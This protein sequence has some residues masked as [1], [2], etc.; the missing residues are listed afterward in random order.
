MRFLFILFTSLCLLS[1]N[2]IAQTRYSISGDVKDKTNNSISHAIIS[3]ENTT[4]GTATNNDGHYSLSLHPGKY[5]IQAAALGYKTQKK[6]IDLRKNETLIFV[7]EDVDVDLS[8][9]EILG[10]SKSQQINEGSFTAKSLDVS[11]T[12]SSLNN[13]NALVGKS[14]GIKIREDGGVGS[15]FDLS[16]NGLSGNSV[17]YFIDG[18]PLTSMG[19]GV[20]LANYPIN[21]VERVEIYKGVVPTELGADALGGAVNIVTKKAIKNYLDASVGAGSFNTYKADFN[22]QFT[23]SKSGIFIRPSIATNYSKNN[24]TMKGVEVWNASNQQFEKVNVKRFHDDYFSFLG[25]VTTGVR[26][27]SWADLLTLTTSFSYVDTQLQTGA[28]QNIVYGKATRE[29]KAYALSAQYQK[30]NFFLDRL[31][32]TLY[33]AHTWD[34]STV[35]DTAY[36]KYRWDGSYTESS[37]NEITGRGKSIRHINRPHTMARGNFNY[38][39]NN[40]HAINLNYMLDHVA[41]DRYDEVDTEFVPAKD[42]LSKHIIGLSYTQN[43][44]NNKLSNV[45]FIKDY[46]THLSIKQQDLYFIT[47]STKVDPSSTKNYIGYGLASRYLLKD[48][49]AIKASYEK[50]VRLATAREILG[51][52]TTLYPNFALNPEKSDNV[53]VGLFGSIAIAPKHQVSYEV[54]YFFRQVKDYIR[55]VISDAEGT[56]QYQNVSDVTVQGVEAEVKYEYNNLI[57]LIGNINYVDQR[58]KTKFQANGK[59]SIT[60]DNQ[61]PNKP[62]FFAN[63]EL[64]VRKKNVFGQK[65]NLIKASYYYQYTHWFYLTW[66]GFG[67]LQSKATIPTQ[68]THSA[69]VTYAIKNEMYNVSLECNNIFDRLSYDN[70]LMQKPG[71]SFFCKFRLFIN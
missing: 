33:F 52:G 5:T 41:N 48:Y 42:K 21:L 20:S 16:I 71:R 43:L 36:R 18:I 24:Y 49:L 34:Y 40:K 30:N 46:L 10:K 50:T 69:S 67:S 54:G 47:N 37:R 4:T 3:V 6:T 39:I 68:S 64:N 8:S 12:A 51:N 70:Y 61:I 2:L 65:N 53:N 28:V 45:L 63:V 7:L 13:L 17:R 22:A 59:P 27:K 29:N 11:Q 44:W 66:K 56:S 15:D 26:N 38:L 14:T 55:L 62:W 19:S 25:Q 60:Y 31:S 9:V 57:Q 23:D 35:V 1:G 58:D 32:T